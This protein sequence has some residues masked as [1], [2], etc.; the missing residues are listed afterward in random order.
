MSRISQFSSLLKDTIFIWVTFRS[1][2]L[3]RVVVV[4]SLYEGI[5]GFGSHPLEMQ[6][7]SLDL[8]LPFRDIWDEYWFEIERQERLE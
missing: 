4:H 3:C 7:H 1:T 8:G 2:L 6:V 5:G